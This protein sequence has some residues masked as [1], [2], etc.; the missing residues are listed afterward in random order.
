MRLWKSF[1][2]EYTYFPCLFKRNL[3]MFILDIEIDMHKE[4]K[5][6]YDEFNI[7]F[8]SINK[9]GLNKYLVV[10]KVNYQNEINKVSNE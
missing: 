1:R 5:E 10:W 8:Q 7:E 2:N 6:L 9:V 4:C 3:P